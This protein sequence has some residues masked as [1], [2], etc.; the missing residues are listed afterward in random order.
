LSDNKRTSQDYNQILN[1]NS[2]VL[3]FQITV[4]NGKYYL[5]PSFKSFN[6]D[7]DMQAEG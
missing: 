5:S 1:P 7:I 3:F 4:P 2:I 6:S